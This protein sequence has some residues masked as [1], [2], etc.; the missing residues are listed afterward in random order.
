MT[1][2]DPREPRE[3]LERIRALRESDRERLGQSTTR[4]RAIDDLVAALIEQGEARGLPFDA[5][6][7][8]RRRTDPRDLRAYLDELVTS[9]DA[10]RRERGAARAEVD[11][12]AQ[13]TAALEEALAAL[14]ARY[15]VVSEGL[16]DVSRILARAPLAEEG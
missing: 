2:P 16:A 9:L 10:A 6:G 1:T 12:L 15:L 4:A 7:R 11:R 5:P 3:A 13:E 8:P 14:R